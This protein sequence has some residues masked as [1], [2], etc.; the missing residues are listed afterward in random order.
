M[1]ITDWMK[2]FLHWKFDLSDEIDVIEKED[3][4]LQPSLKEG[5]SLELN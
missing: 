4:L 2:L 5:E 1:V 3:E